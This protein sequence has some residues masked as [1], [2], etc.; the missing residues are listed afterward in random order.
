MEKIVITGEMVD[1]AESYLPL[2]RKLAIIEAVT[3]LCISTVRLV[4]EKGEASVPNRAEEDVLYSR[5]AAMGVFLRHYLNYEF[6]GWEEDIALP[7]NLYDQWAGS[8]IFNQLERLKSMTAVR[9]KVFDILADYKE[10]VKLLNNAIY[11]RINHQND[12]VLRFNQ[13]IES[14]TTPEA[15]QEAREELVKLAEE[16]KQISAQTVEDADKAKADAEA[17]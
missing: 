16:A 4:D 9:D 8:H 6:E 1:K 10:F 15:F 3:P 7:L 2:A 12:F 11:T 13:M 14:S 5:R 17:E